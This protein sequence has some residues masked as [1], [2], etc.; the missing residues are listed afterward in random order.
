MEGS[1]EPCETLALLYWKLKLCQ[2]TLTVITSDNTKQLLN[3]ENPCERS[4]E[5]ITQK[6][7]AYCVSL[8]DTAPLALL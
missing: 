2:S 1:T 6:R 4:S 7:N 8:I 5:R 3:M